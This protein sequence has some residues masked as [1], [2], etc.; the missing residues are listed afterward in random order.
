MKIKKKG[1]N[2]VVIYGSGAS[3]A[4]G[5]EVKVYNK[6][7]KPPTD[8]NF[9][10]A[11]YDIS[12]NLLKNKYPA[13]WHFKNMYFMSN[14]DPGMEEVLT[15]LDLNYKHIKLA[16]YNWTSETKNYIKKVK[17]LSKHMDVASPSNKLVYD[18]PPKNFSK[19]KFLGDCEREFRRLIYD[20]YSPYKISKNGKNNFLL[21][22]QFL[23]N[24]PNLNF[25]GYITF[26]YDCYL[27]DTLNSEKRQF[28]YIDR[29]SYTEDEDHSV[30]PK[31]LLHSGI[32]I[33]KLHGSLNW[34]EK[35]KGDF[36][37]IDFHLPYSKKSQICPKYV[38]DYNWDQPAIIL[39]TIFKQEI[40]D[41]SRI[42][43]NL[44]QTILQQW[45]TAIT[46][47]TL[48]DK[49]IFVGYSFPTSDFHSKR[50]FQIANMIRRIET[51]EE[52]AD[53]LYCVGPNNNNCY[54]KTCE[55]KVADI[56][57]SKSNIDI[58][59]GFDKLL[60]SNKLKKFLGTK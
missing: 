58:I 8:I 39:P 34:K 40:N 43:H 22:D 38:D 24:K 11:I 29:N 12:P 4:S 28:K 14:S 44:T 6:S 45:R 31:G 32:P 23:H 7:I 16:S 13:L 51:I 19:Y 10:K 26:N 54:K 46:M 5:Y 52:V 49:I 25:I 20:I 2:I 42:E 21:L 1:K 56:F 53:I 35:L 36:Y 55:D 47:L 9:F 17:K 3:H 41:D 33:V 48:A 37:K 50:I 60:E 27:E 15:A 30:I 59:F 57:G 18:N